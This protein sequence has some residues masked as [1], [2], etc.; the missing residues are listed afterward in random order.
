MPAQ[1]NDRASEDLDVYWRNL[2]SNQYIVFM[3]CERAS[4]DDALRITGGRQLV[5]ET[6]LEELIP[7]G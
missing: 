4:V 1:L 7:V 3:P 2:R 6:E 5:V